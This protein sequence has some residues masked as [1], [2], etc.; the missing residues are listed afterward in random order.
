[1]AITLYGYENNPRTRLVAIVAAARNISLDRLEVIP[2][3]NINWDLLIS[4]FPRSRGKIPAIEDNGVKLTEVI[5]ICVYLAKVSGPGPLMGDGS[6]EQ[7]AD[8]VS[9]MNW[10][11][12]EMLMIL[13][14][15]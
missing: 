8:V 4:R 15:W 7:E 5:A 6:L 1:M 13:A 10:A 11:N 2:R 3:K 9:W 12:Q 14:K